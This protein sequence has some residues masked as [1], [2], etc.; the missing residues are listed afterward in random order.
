M[1]KE[2]YSI[3]VIGFISFYFLFG[4]ISG[5]LSTKQIFPFFSW[6]LFGD[7]PNKRI[8]HTVIVDLYNGTI[9][10]P[11]QLFQEAKEI[12]W[13]SDSITA[14]RLIQ[15]F[16]MAYQ[17]GDIKEA[18]RLRKIFEANFIKAPARYRLVRLIYDPLVRWKT[19]KYERIDIQEFTVGGHSL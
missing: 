8:E 3:F 15:D 5:L 17:W 11:P 18:D 10:S 7:I 6:N 19:G 9:V 1:N 2:K 13:E 4:I 12:V 16:A 14:R